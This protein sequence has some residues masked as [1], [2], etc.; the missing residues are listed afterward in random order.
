MATWH[1]DTVSYTHMP[2]SMITL[3]QELSAL[4]A[5]DVTALTFG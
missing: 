5:C 4:G 3:G 2:K 1:A